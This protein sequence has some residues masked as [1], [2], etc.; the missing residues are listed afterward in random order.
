MKAPVPET[1]PDVVLEI[2]AEVPLATAVM[3]VPWG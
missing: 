3:V 2:V 1:L